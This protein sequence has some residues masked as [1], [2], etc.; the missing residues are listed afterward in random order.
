[1]IAM[2]C[3]SRFFKFGQIWLELAI[4]IPD[5]ISKKGHKFALLRNNVFTNLITWCGVL[6]LFFTLDGLGIVSEG[7]TE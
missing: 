7:L 5:Q 4:K 2:F 6:V 3:F 1:M